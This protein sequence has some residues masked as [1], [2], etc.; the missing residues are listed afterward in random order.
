MIDFFAL[1][2]AYKSPAE[3]QAL[4]D[5]RKA[6]RQGKKYEDNPH[7]KGSKE[8]TAWSKG[9]NSQRA[10]MKGIREARRPDAAADTYFNS[11]SAAVQHALA[12]AKKKGFD[13]DEGDTDSQIT[14]GSGKPSKG[15]TVRHTLKLSKGGKAQKK[16]LH[17][18]VYNRGT[19]KN[20]FELNSYI[21]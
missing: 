17:I 7:K 20:P 6:A 16:A 1:R 5:G 18:Q 14:F 10:K 8:F 12:Q 3:A 4:A 13:V 9:H 2:E 11:Y 15:K 19:D 21:S